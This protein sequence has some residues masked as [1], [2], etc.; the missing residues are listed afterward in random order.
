M[1]KM[2]HVLVSDFD[3]TMTKIDFFDL[4]RERYPDPAGRDYWQMYV[5]GKITHFEALKGIF[6]AARD[7]DAEMSKLVEDMQLDP[8]LKD[9]LARLESAGWSVVV[10]SAG[11]DWYINKL[12]RARGITIPVHA[13]PGEF[14]PDSG[15]VMQLPESSPYFRRD[16]GI[17]KPG[18]VR[19]ALDRGGLVAFAG[20]GRPD[21]EPAL[22]VAPTRRFARGW[23]AHRLDKMQE[24]YRPFEHWRQIADRLI[25]ES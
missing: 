6:A 8:T 19:A 3:G 15:V 12:F 17:D 7:V 5:D 2:E 18:I 1:N 13:N 25:E 9:S 20:D 14:H 21:L 11:C 16:T 24:P 23:L 10:A 22:M 4:V